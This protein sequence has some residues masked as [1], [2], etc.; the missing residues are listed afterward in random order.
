MLILL[1]AL[2]SALDYCLSSPQACEH[3][4]ELGWVCMIPKRSP[5]S[6]MTFC[7]I[8]V[9]H[10]C[11]GQLHAGAVCPD[12][13]LLGIICRG[14]LPC[15]QVVYMTSQPRIMG[16]LFTSSKQLQVVIWILV[17][18]ILAINAYMIVSVTEG[19]FGNTWWVDVSFV[20][21]GLFY[22]SFVAYLSVGP[23]RF[24][25]AVSWL[26]DKGQ[27]VFSASSATLE[28]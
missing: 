19:L 1:A 24:Y 25:D 21:C 2:S 15:L 8:A 11:P 5:T 6:C 3:K 9:T 7:L 22:Y 13:S 18:S 26:R 14:C 28:I 17:G 4:V 16:K 10:A 20:V 12:T 23:N 27:T